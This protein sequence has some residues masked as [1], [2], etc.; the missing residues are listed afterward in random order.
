MKNKKRIAALIAAMAIATVSTVSMSGSAVKPLRDASGDGIIY[1]NDALVTISYLNGAY[2]PTNIKSF[3]F[4]GNGIISAMDTAKIQHYLLHNISEDDLPEA[5]TETVSAVATTRQYFRHNCSDTNKRSKTEYSLTVNPYDNTSS[6]TTND[7]PV[8]YSIIG[9]DNR[10]NADEDTAIVKLVDST[11]GKGIASGFIVNDHVIA[12]AVHCVYTGLEFRDL[13]IRII[14]E[15]NNLIKTVSP[16]YIHVPKEAIYNTSSIRGT[17]DYALL[18]V[19]E[20]LSEYG[21]FQLGVATDEYIDNHGNVVVSGFPG[22]LPENYTGKSGDIR[23]KASGNFYRSSVSPYNNYR[24]FYDAD[25]VGGNS[26]GPV[27]VEEGFK[28]GD[29]WY[30]YKTVVAIHSGGCASFSLNYNYFDPEYNSGVTI[31][32]DILNFYYSNSYLTE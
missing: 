12:T 18:Y 32:P 27:Y 22:D 13:S 26:G 28:V 25:A 8:P 2:N 4:D 30:K 7:E 21:T 3:D 9:T 19:E 29:Q 11:T 1:L 31:T 20:D 5:S 24:C 6:S 16:Q 14:D 15:N 23:F 10:V 17:H